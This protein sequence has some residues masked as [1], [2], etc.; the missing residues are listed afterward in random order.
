MQINLTNGLKKAILN[1]VRH[2]LF[3]KTAYVS[4]IAKIETR[5]IFRTT[6]SFCNIMGCSELLQ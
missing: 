6:D 2:Y 4:P 1:L 3:L 5:K